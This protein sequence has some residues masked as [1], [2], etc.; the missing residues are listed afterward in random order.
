MQALSEKKPATAK[1][2]YMKDAFL[3]TTMGPRWG[4]NI[5]GVDPRSKHYLL[6]LK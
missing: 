2:K 6:N 1:G 3:K 4:L 5:E